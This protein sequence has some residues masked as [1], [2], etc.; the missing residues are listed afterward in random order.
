MRL[1]LF[2]LIVML[3]QLVIAQN[4]MKP[5]ISASYM[6]SVPFDGLFSEEAQIGGGM[7]FNDYLSLQINVRGIQ[8]AYN[9]VHPL[10]IATLSLSPSYRIL[11]R[12]YFASP[13]IGIDVGT[14][15]WSNGKG[16]YIDRGWRFITKPANSYDGYSY[17]RG[18][19][20]GR[21]KLL[22]D[23]RIWNFNLLIGASYNVY[24]IKLKEFNSDTRAI[25]LEGTV[26]YTFPM[27]K[28]AAKATSD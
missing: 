11:K 16:R 25:G 17:S 14:Q 21:A 12:K 8:N 7:Q 10:R 27:K 28:R 5:I 6:Y 18:L 15:V 23:F 19:F 13:V 22:A 9:E 1:V 4:K 24:Y 2:L 26:M 3:G 20:F